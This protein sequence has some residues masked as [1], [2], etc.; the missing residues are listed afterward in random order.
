MG[1]GGSEG[2]SGKSGEQQ[3]AVIIQVRDAGGSGQVLTLES[4][5]VLKVDRQDF[6]TRGFRVRKESEKA[7][8]TLG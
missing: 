8:M 4:G 3:L 5:C 7:R 2:T 1:G 6:L